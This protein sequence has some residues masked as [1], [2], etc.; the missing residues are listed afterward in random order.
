MRPDPATRQARARGERGGGRRDAPLARRSA[1][2]ARRLR[3]RAQLRHARR[4]DRAP[5]PTASPSTAERDDVAAVVVTHGTDTMEETV[6]A[7]RPAARVSGSRSSSPARSGRRTRP[8]PTGRGTCETPIVVALAA[9]SAD[10]G[11]LVA[12]AGEIH[13][14]REVRKVHTSALAAFGS[15]GYG[16]LGHVDGDR[17]RLP[18]P[19]PTGARRFRARMARCPH[20]DLIRLYAGSDDR[21]LRCSVESGAPRD[22]ARGHRPRQRERAGA[23]GRSRRP[24][25]RQEC[26]SSSAL[27]ASPGGSSRCTEEAAARTWRRPELVFAGDLAGPKARVLVQLALAA[28]VD[29]SRGA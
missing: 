20:V 4:A 26:R 12:F 13:A 25:R 6:Y 23:S 11:A 16:P 10:R 15:P 18:S 3:P 9:E 29:V 1:P 27:A 22:R 2:R 24:R 7:D 5:W 19:R 17:V 8:T 14:A 28:G 21:F